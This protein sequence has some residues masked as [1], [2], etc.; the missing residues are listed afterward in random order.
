M[1]DFYA[2]VRELQDTHLNTIIGL[3]KTENSEQ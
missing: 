3:I 2:H 1:I